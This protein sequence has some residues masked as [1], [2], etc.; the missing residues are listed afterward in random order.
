MLRVMGQT[1][2]PDAVALLKKEYKSSNP[3]LSKAGFKGMTG[4][5]GRCFT[6][7]IVIFGNMKVC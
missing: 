7:N 6:V 1:G 5:P 3:K 2:D 4:W